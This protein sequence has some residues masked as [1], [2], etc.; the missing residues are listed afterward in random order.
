M[1]KNKGL[2]FLIGLTV[3]LALWAYFGEYKRELKETESNKEASRIIKLQKDQIQRIELKKGEGTPVVIERSVDGWNLS[4]PVQDQA[5]NEIVESLLDQMVGEKSVD[6]IQVKSDNFD[7]YGFKPAL[8]SVSLLS[9]SHQQEKIE[10]SSKKNFEGLVWLKKEGSEELLTSS[11]VWM[12]FLTKPTD[13]LRN[14]RLFRGS[15]SK[16]QKISVQNKNASFELH[17]QDGQWIA[18][19]KSKWRMDQNAVREILTQSITSKGTA[20]LEKADFDQKKDLLV[21]LEFSGDGVHWKANLY[22]DSKSKDVL[23]QISAPNLKIRY[24]P[25]TLEDYRAKRLVDFRDRTEPFKFS[26]G[27]VVRIVA[28][29]RIKSFSLIKK[30]GVWSLEKPDPQVIISQSLADDLVRK[31]GR[32]TVYKFFEKPVAQKDLTN[33]IQFFDESG[34]KIFELRFGEFKDH[35]G[36]ALTSQFQEVFQIDDAQVSHLQ[37]QE[38]LKPKPVAQDAEKKKE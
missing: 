25:Q 14:L 19:E 4:Q 18:P 31:M 22:Q 3:L 1:K 5:D 35:E 8:G 23:A 17:Y 34:R 24:A 29:T 7:Q 21:A 33:K 13:Q 10:V 15:I 6:R 16:V 9:N 11:E 30:D 37:L 28:E 36:F 20:L 32:M 27:E 2:L 38:I 12:S 26:S